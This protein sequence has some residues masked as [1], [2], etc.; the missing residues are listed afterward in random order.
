MSEDFSEILGLKQG[1]K[2]KITKFYQKSKVVN[3]MM[4][5]GRRASKEPLDGEKKGGVALIGF[6]MI[7]YFSLLFFFFPGGKKNLT[8]ERL[9]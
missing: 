5:S 3:K 2:N 4:R 1:G 7:P 9:I 8:T 6:L